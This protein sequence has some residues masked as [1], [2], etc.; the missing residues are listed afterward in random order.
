MPTDTAIIV[1]LITLAFIAFAVTLAYGEWCTR[2]IR[3]D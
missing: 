1:A 2:N 3:R